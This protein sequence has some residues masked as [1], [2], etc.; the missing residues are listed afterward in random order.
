M[1][2]L[3]AAVLLLASAESSGAEWFIH[4]GNVATL[5]SVGADGATLRVR[6]LNGRPYPDVYFP[7][8]M[9][10][11]GLEAGVVFRF[12]DGPLEP[13][14]LPIGND[15]RELAIWPGTPAFAMGQI[16]HAQRLRVQV[17]GVVL[18]FDLNGAT[19]ALAGLAPCVP[20]W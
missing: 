20:R 14:I 5:P 8:P 1:R 18:D 2:I 13:R 15:L 12:D 6:C 3:F 19:A 7:R 16:V 10:F 4:V 11:P 9:G 17:R